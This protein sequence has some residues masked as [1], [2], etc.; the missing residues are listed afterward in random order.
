MY[1]VKVFTGGIICRYNFGTVLTKM[2]QNPLQTVRL[3][4]LNRL[5]TPKD[6]WRHL[7]CYQEGNAF[8]YFARVSFYSSFTDVMR[9]VAKSSFG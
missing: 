6:V 2:Q 5:A 8:N 4:R 3:L 9:N 7:Y 1:Q